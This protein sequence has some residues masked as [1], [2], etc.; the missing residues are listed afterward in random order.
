MAKKA[1]QRPPDDD[2]PE[3]SDDEKLDSFERILALG[4]TCRIL[5]DDFLKKQKV[6]KDAKNLW[7]EKQMELQREIDEANDP[8]QR[9]AMTYED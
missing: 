3:L 6:A 1:N 9:L 2:R 8:Q 5:Q 7:E 4:A